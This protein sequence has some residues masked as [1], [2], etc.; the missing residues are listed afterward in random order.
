MKFHESS[1][2]ASILSLTALHILAEKVHNIGGYSMIKNISE[3]LNID[4]K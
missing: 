4:I 2:N 3:G 1:Y